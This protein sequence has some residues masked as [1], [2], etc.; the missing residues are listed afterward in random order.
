LQGPD[1]TGEILRQRLGPRGLDALDRE[2]GLLG[3][4]RGEQ[5]ADLRLVAHDLVLVHLAHRLCT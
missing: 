2:L 1:E 3:E 5:P 4:L